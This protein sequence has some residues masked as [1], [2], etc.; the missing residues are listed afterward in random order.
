MI[1]E[2][3]Y[4][5]MAVEDASLTRPLVT[6]LLRHLEGSKEEKGPTNPHFII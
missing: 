4:A 2:L 1:T 3:V 5:E 6:R